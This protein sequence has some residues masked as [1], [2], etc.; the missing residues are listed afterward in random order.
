MLSSW[1]LTNECYARCN[2][3]KFVIMSVENYPINYFYREE[4]NLCHTKNITYVC[5][6]LIFSQNV[7][8]L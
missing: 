3:Q 8:C 7:I 5:Y 6:C 1:D 2:Q 4:D